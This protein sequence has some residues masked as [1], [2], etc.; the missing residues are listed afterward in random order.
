MMADGAED[1][2]EKIGKH[3]HSNHNRQSRGA[4]AGKAATSDGPGPSGELLFSLCQSGK[5]SFIC[6][7]HLR[8]AL[9]TQFA[10]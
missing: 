5:A 1:D 8:L 9:L 4:S 10:G 6:N 7:A 3:R 2:V